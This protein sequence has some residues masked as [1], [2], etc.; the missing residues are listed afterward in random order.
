MEPQRK[1]IFFSFLVLYMEGEQRAFVV[2]CRLNDACTLSHLL[3]DKLLSVVLE[4]CL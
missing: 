3:L 1:R 4:T 2:D